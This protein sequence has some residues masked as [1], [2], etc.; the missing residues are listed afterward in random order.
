VALEAQGVQ[1]VLGPPKPTKNSSQVC[2][3]GIKHTK[4]T[5]I[6]SERAQDRPEEAAMSWTVASSLL[7]AETALCLEDRGVVPVQCN[8]PQSKRFKFETACPTTEHMPKFGVALQYFTYLAL[9]SK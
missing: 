5:L 3:R 8:Q 1:L 6:Y 2:F 9:Q 7:M 4:K